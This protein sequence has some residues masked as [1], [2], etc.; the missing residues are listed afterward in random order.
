MIVM[1]AVRERNG[2]LMCEVIDFT[3]ESYEAATGFMIKIDKRLGTQDWT[4][5]SLD[6]NIPYETWTVSV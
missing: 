2:K 6:I 3:D 1:R 4:L 5:E